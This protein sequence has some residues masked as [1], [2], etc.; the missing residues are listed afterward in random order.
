VSSFGTE[1]ADEA[2]VIPYILLQAFGL[3]KELRETH[4]D[5]VVF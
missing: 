3:R 4:W 1:E 2:T 5:A